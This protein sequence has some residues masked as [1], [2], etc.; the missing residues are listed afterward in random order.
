MHRWGEAQTEENATSAGLCSVGVEFLQTG[1]D[2]VEAVI[3]DFV[4]VADGCELLELLF[5]V[6]LLVIGGDDGVEGGCLTGC[7]LLLQVI[8]VALLGEADLSGAK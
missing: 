6:L 1:V 4:V 3:D 2:K 7:N 8:E 5:E